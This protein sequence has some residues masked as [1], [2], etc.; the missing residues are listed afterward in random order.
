MRLTH[1]LPVVRSTKW[2]TAVKCRCNQ[3]VYIH[4]SIY[5]W[6]AH[7]CSEFSLP[8]CSCGEVLLTVNHAPEV[9]AI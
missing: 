1:H 5:R 9:P 6:L 3:I 7:A 4:T 2:V 8:R